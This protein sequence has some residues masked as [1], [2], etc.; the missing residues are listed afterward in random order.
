MSAGSARAGHESHAARG[1]TRSNAPTWKYSSTSTV[2]R[3]ETTPVSG[4]ERNR[5]PA[6][7]LG[8]PRVRQVEALLQRHRGSPCQHSPSLGGVERRPSHFTEPRRLELDGR[9]G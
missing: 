3:C 9:R 1:M 5:S 4:I 2:K 7:A 6:L 8:E